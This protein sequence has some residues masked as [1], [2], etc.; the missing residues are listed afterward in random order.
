[1]RLVETIRVNSY[2]LWCSNGQSRENLLP[3]S[4]VMHATGG[5]PGRGSIVVRGIFCIHFPLFTQDPC[6]HIRHKAISSQSQ[7]YFEFLYVG[8]TCRNAGSTSWGL[9]SASVSISAE[10]VLNP[11]SR[12]LPAHGGRYIPESL[13]L[14]WLRGV[15]PGDDSCGYRQV[16]VGA[17]K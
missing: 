4:Q 13:R 3:V 11:A 12:W 2:T 6:D 7:V 17:V 16:H 8:L 9:G 14:Q 1:M 10:A 5:S 15:K